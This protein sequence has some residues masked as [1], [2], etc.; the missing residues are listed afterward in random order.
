MADMTRERS[1]YTAIVD[2]LAE[3]YAV[4]Y[5]LEHLRDRTVPIE[6]GELVKQLSKTS[7]KDD[8]FNDNGSAVADE[9]ARIGVLRPRQDKRWDV[10][11]V[12]RYGYGIKR[13]GGVARPR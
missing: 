11:D 8:G 5:R 13:K 9:L 1:Y 2:E 3:E 10:P 6:H 12:Y 7:Q 4:V